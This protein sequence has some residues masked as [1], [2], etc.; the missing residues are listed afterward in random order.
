M[1]CI[2]PVDGFLQ[3]LRALCDEHKSLLIF[4][5][6]MCGLRVGP[7]TAQ[8]L[9]EVIPDITTL[10]KIL[11]GGMPVGAFGGKKEIMQFLAPAGPVYQAG[12]LSGNPIAMAAGLASLNLLKQPDFF[13]H[14]YNYCEKLV[15]GLQALANKHGIPFTTNHVG[16]MF[17]IFFSNEKNI[18]RFSQVMESNQA[19]FK[20]FF[21]TMLDQGVY[22]APSAFE[23]GFICSAH[24]QQTLD[25]TLAAADIAF[26]GLKN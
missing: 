23:A 19:A 8:Q 5:E 4:D 24:N 3:G 25:K 14:L 22:L 16:S 21:H 6:V 26:A 12:T 15:N 17:G 18:T 7:G 2:P 10:G 20:Q 13:T 1:N 11:G 9:Y